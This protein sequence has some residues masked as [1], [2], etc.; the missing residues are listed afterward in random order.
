VDN[1]QYNL[2]TGAQTTSTLDGLADYYTSYI[3]AY[4][5]YD[6][7]GTAQTGRKSSNSDYRFGFQGQEMDDEI[8]GEGN[9]IN[10]EY[11]MHDP[12]LGRFFAVDPLA[13]EYP[14]NSP[15]AFSENVVINAVELEGLEKVL[16]SNHDNKTHKNVPKTPYKADELKQD[17]QLIYHW[18]AN[19]GIKSVEVLNKNGEHLITYG[20]KEHINY[21]QINNL[22]S[23]QEY[24]KY[25]SV[26]TKENYEDGLYSY[27][28]YGL[29]GGKMLEYGGLRGVLKL[30]TTET[31]DGSLEGRREFSFGANTS[32]L[33]LE[34]Q[35]QAGTQDNNVHAN[36]TAKLFY[37]GTKIAITPKGSHDQFYGI[38]FDGAAEAGAISGEGTIGATVFG[39][40]N[41]DISYG[42]SAG[43]ASASGFLAAGYNAKENSVLLGLGG[44]FG[45]IFGSK[46]DIK[47]EVDFDD[48]CLP[49]GF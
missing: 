6:P 42:Y 17:I 48:L 36:L 30:G 23:K 14:H 24:E 37:A 21:H 33:T 22:I 18:N 32:V 45:L 39:G 20:K 27:T 1:G 3:V 35:G 12:R 31:Y 34:G 15:Y 44:G 46:A 19:G 5:D 26:T 11:R 16:V 38:Y 8:K 49:D 47:I 40:V 4:T 43:S 9:S 13:P 41:F 10:Y 29:S 7:Y 2:L 25:E 28:S